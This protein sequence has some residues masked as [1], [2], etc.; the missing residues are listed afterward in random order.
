MK[1]RCAF[2][3]AV[4]LAVFSIIVCITAVAV[5][6]FFFGNKEKD[7]SDVDA[8]LIPT[9]VIDAGHGGIDGGCVSVGDSK[10]PEK[11]L[12]L[13]IAST[14]AALF[15]I[16]GY[17]TVMTRETDNMLDA[18]GLTGSA[19]VRDL[20]AR[21]MIAQEY[22][23]ALFISV[24]CNKFPDPSCAGMQVYYSK[25]DEMSRLYAEGIQSSVVELIQNDNHRVSKP[26]DSSI[27]VLH[28]AKQPSVLIECG[29]LSNPTEAS[30]LEDSVYQ[31]KLAIAIILPILQVK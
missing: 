15:R 14:L 12:N 3:T 24:H 20:R 26:A 7:T 31:Q 8:A 28:Q 9:V 18:E 11:E 4:S 21:L 1:N 13:K 16:S 27:Y 19:K 5:Q 25:N 6:Y 17:N 23:D 10:T 2:R 29:F 30:L 22:P